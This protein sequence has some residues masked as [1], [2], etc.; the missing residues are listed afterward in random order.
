[1]RG[2]YDVFITLSTFAAVF[3]LLAFTAWVLTRK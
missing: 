2:E 3:L 1:M